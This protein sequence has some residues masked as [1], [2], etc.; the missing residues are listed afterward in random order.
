MEDFTQGIRRGICKKGVLLMVNG[1]RIHV[2]EGD[3]Y[4]SLDVRGDEIG[5]RN[6]QVLYN[7]F[8]GEVTRYA[9][10]I[11]VSENRKLTQTLYYV[12]NLFVGLRDGL[13]DVDS[14]IPLHLDSRYEF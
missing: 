7:R 6:V 12:T 9:D 13:N 4:L 1:Y 2:H 8:S 3:I 10:G 5:S 11:T 14:I